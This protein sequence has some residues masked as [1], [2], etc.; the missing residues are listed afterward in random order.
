VTGNAAE[1]WTAVKAAMDDQV[2]LS[3][4]CVETSALQIT[5]LI[6]PIMLLLGFTRATRFTLIMNPFGLVVYVV[7]IVVVW[8]ITSDNESNTIEGCILLALY[9]IFAVAFAVGF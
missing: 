7:S 2:D 8:F 5:F 6:I 1:H 4:T 9:L 3:I